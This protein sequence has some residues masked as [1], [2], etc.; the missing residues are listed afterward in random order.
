MIKYP[1]VVSQS[2]ERKIFLIRGNKVMLDADLA[3]LYGVSTKVMMQ[4]VRRNIQRFP[5]EF[6]FQLSEREYNSLRSQ[7]VTSKTGRGGRR[8]LPFVFTEH[9]VAMLATVLR[10]E[11]A[12][13]MSIQ[14][15]KAFVRLRQF[16]AS[17][18]DLE[19]KL[20]LLEERVNTHDKD[21]QSII[22]AIK[23]MLT[24]VVKE[25]KQIG[26]RVAEPISRYKARQK[27]KLILK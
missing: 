23:Q 20:L 24:P 6:M 10:S 13:Q 18:K 15:I 16:L 7:I 11:R 25:K 26:F 5:T 2:I 9:G 21:I 17:H 12:I 3:I 4:S 8:Y 27:N 1:R 22:D 19:K 14:I